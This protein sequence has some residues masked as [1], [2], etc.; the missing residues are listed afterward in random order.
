MDENVP[1]ERVPFLASDHFQ[2][3]KNQNDEQNQA[4][5]ASAVITNSRTH[6]VPA[7]A[8]T[9]YQDN[10][11]DQQQ[12]NSPV[13]LKICP[14]ATCRNVRGCVARPAPDPLMHREL[15]P[16]P[17]RPAVD[18]EKCAAGKFLLSKSM[19]AMQRAKE[20]LYLQASYLASFPGDLLFVTLNNHR[21]EARRQIRL[22]LQVKKAEILWR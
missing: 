9:E 18:F 6:P 7:V 19:R 12:H 10:E 11:N 2:Q 3:K 21:A 4:D 5:S 17:A 1:R 13:Q 15:Q 16:L 8:E 20:Q 22:A 14:T